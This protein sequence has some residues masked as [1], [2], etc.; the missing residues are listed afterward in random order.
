MSSPYTEQ[1]LNKLTV[2]ELQILIKQNK[3][4][5]RRSKLRKAE[6]IANIIAVTTP[7][8]D[9][10]KENPLEKLAK[11]AA[12][13]KPKTKKHKPRVVRWHAIT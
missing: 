11:V 5:I 1:E 12:V 6:Y 3:W 8:A 10:P 9:N 4:K 2:A 7:Q 13:T